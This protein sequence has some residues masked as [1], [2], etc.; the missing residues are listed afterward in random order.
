[1]EDAAHAELLQHEVYQKP[2]KVPPKVELWETPRNYHD[3]NLDEDKLPTKMKV[4]RVQTTARNS[5]SV[6]ARAYGFTDSPDAEVLAKGFNH[7]KEYGA[8]GIGRHGNFL[9]WGYQAPPSQMTEAGKKLF[10]NCICYIHK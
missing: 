9:Q 3:R 8:V 6:V 1:M 2:F 5:G 7:G 4:W 10:L